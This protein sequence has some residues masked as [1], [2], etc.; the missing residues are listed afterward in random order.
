MQILFI[1]QNMPGQFVH[2]ARHFAA[3]HRHRVA[4]VTKR[5]N[6]QMP[7][8]LKIEYGLMPAKGRIP[9][10]WLIN[11]QNAVTYGE[12]AARAIATLLGKHRFRPDVVVAHPGWGEALFVKDLLPDVPLLNYVEFYYRAFGA[13]SYFDPADVPEPKDLF[14][15]R[16]KNANNLLNLE[17]CDWGLC[18][19]YWQWWQQPPLLRSKLSVVHDGINVDVVRP[20]P[21]A[22]LPL[23]GGPVLTRRDPVVT[24]VARH[25]EPYRGFPQFM[26]AIERVM[27]R[28]PDVQVVVVGA[29]GA[30]YGRKPPPGTTYRELLLKEVKVDPGRIHFL[31]TIPYATY[32]KVLQ[33]S[34]VHVY[35]TVPFVL[36]WSMLEAMAAGCQLVASAPPPV[37]EVAEDG[38]NALLVDFFDEAGIAERILEALDRQEPLAPLRQQARQT[39]LDRYALSRCLPQQVALIKTLAAGQAPVPAPPPPDPLAARFR[40]AT[41]RPALSARAARARGRT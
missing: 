16:I 19:T 8:V 38:R 39:V 7:G 15:I 35:L 40:A 37:I 3:D 29:D 24:Y 23:P 6:V 4:F 5:K 41:A 13:D 31:G 21:D 11:L 30:G 25:L 27:A 36:S 14:R 10:D 28:R 22:A 26:H 2:L 18:P 17:L 9:H 34:A 12:G 20:D 32:L 33:V 1:H